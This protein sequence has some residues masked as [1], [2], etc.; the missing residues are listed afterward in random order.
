MLLRRWKHLK[1]YGSAR[2]RLVRR[3]IAVAFVAMFGLFLD[4][5]GGDEPLALTLLQAQHLLCSPQQT[6][7]HF[8]LFR[9]L[10]NMSREAAS[11][12]QHAWVNLHWK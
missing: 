5:N 3:F 10:I 1:I 7:L 9:G 12:Q 6:R 4:R 11:A 8:V 2:V